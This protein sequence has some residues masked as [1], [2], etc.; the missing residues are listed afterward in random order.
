MT[1]MYVHVSTIET[2]AALDA[3]GV[4]N[5]DAPL[6]TVSVDRL[7][8]LQRAAAHVLQLATVRHYDEGQFPGEDNPYVCPELHD[9]ATRIP[10]TEDQLED[11]F[12]LEAWLTEMN[13][14]CGEPWFSIQRLEVL[15][16]EQRHLRAV[17]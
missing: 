10:L 7:T 15:S 8:A 2:G 1:A 17:A 3:A 13:N 6:T 14:Q 16:P 9:Y 5:S 12:E 4:V 11:P